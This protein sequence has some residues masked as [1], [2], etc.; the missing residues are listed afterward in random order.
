MNRQ[1]ELERVL[2]DR[3]QDV[4]AHVDDAVLVLDH[5]RVLRFVNGA[6]RR[7][8][9][10]DENESIGGRC[11]F[12]T[13][14]VDCQEACP[15]TYALERSMDRVD[16]FATVY[17]SRDGRPVP[18]NVTV[19]PLR[20]DDGTFRGAVEILRPREPD[21]GFF[22]AGSSPVARAL[23]A[24]LGQHGRT[25][26]HLLLIGDLPACRDVGRAVHRFASLPEEL[27]KVW[28]G[29]WSD[30]PIWPPGT[31]YADGASAD[32]LFADAPPDGWCLIA[33]VPRGRRIDTRGV[34]VEVVELPTVDDVAEDL[35]LMVTAWAGGM[36][37]GVTVSP[38][39]AQRL[40][41]LAQQRGLEAVE[42]VLTA[43]AAAAAAGD[44][45]IEDVH[46]PADGY[47]SF[48]VDEL[49]ETDNPLAALESRL[50]LEV[51]QRSNWRMQEAADRLGVSRVTLWR[52]LKDHGIERPNGNGD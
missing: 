35:A 22:L 10:Y 26:E 44:G 28:A 43:A 52:K 49:L 50:L 4:L 25:R 2:A 17:R 42:T 15:L 31:M 13:N 18:L 6:A 23:R 12:T 3:W 27:F 39:A 8:L 20:N 1:T 9:G 51:L 37:P 40:G 45:C 29:S 34:V 48:L 32:S 16:D 19:I 7:L 14:G 11:R 36:V 21:P 24:R 5:E 38:A 30:V 46:I 41:E 33:G 47:S